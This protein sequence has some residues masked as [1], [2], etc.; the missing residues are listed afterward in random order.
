MARQGQ[1]LS[2]KTLPWFY[3][4][5]GSG[6]SLNVGR[7]AA[8]DL[9]ARPPHCN[10]EGAGAPSADALRGRLRN[11]VGDVDALDSIQLLHEMDHYSDERRS[12]VVLLSTEL[13]SETQ[14]L[15]HTIPSTVLK[16]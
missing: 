2:S 6:V 16:L 14:S 13:L 12:V 8:I 15:T 9:R 4:A 10:V 5:H 3:F 7:T 11:C 1:Q